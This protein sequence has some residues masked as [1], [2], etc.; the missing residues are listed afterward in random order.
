MRR[1]AQEAENG[2]SGWT[3]VSHNG[4]FSMVWHFS[5]IIRTILN[6]QTFHHIILQIFQ[7]SK[8]EPSPLITKTTH[9]NRRAFKQNGKPSSLTV[10]NL[11]ANDAIGQE[12]FKKQMYQIKKTPCIS[13]QVKPVFLGGKWVISRVWHFEMAKNAIYRNLFWIV[14][15]LFADNFVIKLF[16]ASRLFVWCVC[17]RFSSRN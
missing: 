8:F 13:R 9:S 11:A 6:F 14:R 4:R 7:I 1:M 15:A 16:F 3:K 12:L 17:R 2:Q 10:R 5:E